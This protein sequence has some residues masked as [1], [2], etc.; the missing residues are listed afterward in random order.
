MLKGVSLSV[1]KGAAVAL[2]GANGARQ[3]HDFEGDFPN[4]LR[5][6]RGEVIKGV[7]MFEGERVDRTS[8]QRPVRRGAIQVAKANGSV[9][10]PA[11]KKSS[12]PF[13]PAATAAPRRCATL[14]GS[15]PGRGIRAP[16]RPG[17][18]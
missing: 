4:L 14:N 13:S 11:L 1:P 7:I 6:E 3:D 10:G 18:T 16:Q 5:A 8:A 12:T 15:T 2:L 17:R 9:N